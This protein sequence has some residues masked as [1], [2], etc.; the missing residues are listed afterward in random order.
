MSMVS[1]MFG[2]LRDLILDRLEKI[3]TVPTALEGDPLI[4]KHLLMAGE[5]LDAGELVELYQV[6]GLSAEQRERFISNFTLTTFHSL[7]K[8]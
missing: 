3:E 4:G 8:A 2:P 7:N 5:F 1:K 6:I